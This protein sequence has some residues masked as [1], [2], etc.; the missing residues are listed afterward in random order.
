LG[1][2]EPS[3]CRLPIDSGLGS[4]PPYWTHLYIRR[5]P[6]LWGWS[7]RSPGPLFFSQWVTLYLVSKL[8]S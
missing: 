6:E 1:D 3:S 4:S 8:T 7:S 2:D 5:A